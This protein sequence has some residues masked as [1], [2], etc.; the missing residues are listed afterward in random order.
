MAAIVTPVPG[1]SRCFSS[2]DPATFTGREA[3]V[4]QLRGALD[5]GKRLL[6]IQGMTGIGKT[7]LAERLAAAELADRVY[8]T[9]D[10]QREFD[11]GDFVA[12]ALAILQALG[13]E[14]AQQLP[15]GQILPYLVQTLSRGAYWIQLDSLEALV[16]D[17]AFRDGLWGEFL[18]KFGRSSAASRLVLT[19]QVLPEWDREGRSRGTVEVVTLHGLETDRVVELFEKSGVV[20]QNPT[21]QDYLQQIAAD[22]QQHPFI[23]QITAGEIKLRPFNGDVGRYWRDYY[24]QERQ[25]RPRLRGS[26]RNQVE[27]R[28][29]RV[30]EQLP[31]LARRLLLAGSV[32]GRAVLEDFYLELL[33]E[34]PEEE[35]AEALDLLLGRELVQEREWTGSGW[36][37][38]QHNLVR[39]AALARL[40]QDS[41]AWEAAQRR[42]ADLWLTRYEPGK[43]ASNLEIM[44]GRLEAF[45]HFCVVEDWEKSAEIY[46]AL[47]K[48]QRT[49]FHQQLLDLGYYQELLG[50]SQK[51]L[52]HTEENLLKI[53]ILMQ[54][55]NIYD[56]TGKSDESLARN[57]EALALTERVHSPFQTYQILANIS[58]HYYCKGK[59]KVAIEFGNRSLEIAEK[60]NYLKQ[61]YAILDTMGL[62]YSGLN[63]YSKAID[64]HK[65]SLRISKLIENSRDQG[66][67]LYNLAVAYYQANDLE[68][69]LNY[70]YQSIPLLKMAGNKEWIFNA[71]NM[72][73]AIGLNQ[74]SG[75]GLQDQLQRNLEE[76]A[77]T[78]V[79]RSEG[80]ALLN[81]GL[82]KLRS[83]QYKDALQDLESA[84]K[85]FTKIR[86][87]GNEKKALET[88][89]YIYVF[90]GDLPTAKD[91]AHRALTLA[92]QL[93]IPLQ[94][95]CAALLES[96][97]NS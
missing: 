43:N 83:H 14:T 23:L 10:C 17:G 58:I 82:F 54:I 28:V 60:Y 38:G 40:R 48:S 86:D 61:C 55:A 8:G 97:E 89:A 27:A 12:G 16:E 31:E 84:I 65:K 56:I 30:I 59:Y 29:Q 76:A 57:K 11:D 88:A 72:L 78:S 25:Q 70:V 21:E 5:Q 4:A 85:I 71:N 3:Q 93:N 87:Q 67:A 94:T 96:L 44:R 45:D 35:R 52:P 18:E 69:A 42:A 2:Y 19:T 13:D 75:Q 68:N 92:Q 53:I 50:M 7:T 90:L 73:T 49:E 22:F 47:S 66:L 9:V 37:L 26:Q 80:I 41:A 1:F 95:K 91:Y 32:L 62:C 20:A 79:P 64:L 36:L 33:P 51:L 15:E 77:S 46:T 63:Q 24:Q 6:W 39:E 74:A 34:V 81:S